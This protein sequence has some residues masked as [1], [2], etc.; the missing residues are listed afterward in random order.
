M[1]AIWILGAG[2]FGRQAGVTLSRKYPQSHI[3]LIDH[4]HDACRGAR[5]QGFSTLH[6]D[7]VHHLASR[8]ADENVEWIIPAIPVHVAFRWIQ[9]RLQDQYRVI[10]MAVPDDLV[11]RL[12][13]P[14]TG[15]NHTV[16]T[17]IADFL[18]P[19]DCLQPKW[20]CSVTGQPRP[21]SV[22]D[23]LRNYGGRDFRVVVVRSISL[24]PGV[25]GYRPRDL[26]DALSMIMQ[27]RLPVILSTACCCHGVV[28]AF[29]FVSLKTGVTNT[30]T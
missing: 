24:G 12:P 7:G 21:C 26:F 11:S 15:P 19:P 9:H 25:G 17:S 10:K 1:T 30:E 8:L 14:M 5:L 3:T 29:R 16:Y 28:D 27:S 23:R 13:N 20:G 4:N 18:C 2:R 6:R 22:L